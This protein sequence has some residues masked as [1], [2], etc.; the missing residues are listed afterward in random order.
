MNNNGSG[1]KLG[2]MPIWK[3]FLYAT[4]GCFSLAAL[5]GIFFIL[6]GSTIK[7]DTAAFLGRLCASAAVIGLFSLFSMN[8]LFRRESNKNYVKIASTAAL[9]LNIVWVLPWLMIVWNAFDGLKAN[10]VYPEYP[11]YSYSSGSYNRWGYGVDSYDESDYNKR[12]DEYQT[13]LSQYDKC[14]EP[15]EN[16][17]EMAWKVMANGIILAILLTL[18]AEFLGFEDYNLVI[19]AMKYT[20]IVFAAVIAGYAIL[21]I[22]VMNFQIEEATARILAVGFIILIFCAVVTPILVKVQK[23]KTT[24]HVAETTASTPI[25]QAPASAIDEK[26]LREQIRAEVEAELREK[27]RAEILAELKAEKEAPES[28]PTP[29]KNDDEAYLNGE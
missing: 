7:G 6:V 3:Y 13:A 10:C 15:Y 2:N 22:N 5:I 18:T 4:I 11:S 17:I 27:I 1:I 24:N 25:A 28:Q 20:T 14:R 19:K 29:P 9:A 8:N 12:Y 26:A 23:K 21:Q 16:A